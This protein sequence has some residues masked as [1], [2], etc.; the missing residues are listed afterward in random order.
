MIRKISKNEIRKR[1]HTRILAYSA[2]YASSFYGPFR[3]AVGSAKA[4]GTTLLSKA[5]YQ[6][7]PANRRE[8]LVEATLEVLWLGQSLQMPTWSS[9]ALYWFAGQAWHVPDAPVTKPK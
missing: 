2:K 6:M 3:D 4:A 7:N 1:I 8:A 9:S 5:T